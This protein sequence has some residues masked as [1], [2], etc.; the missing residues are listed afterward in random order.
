MINSLLDLFSFRTL[1]F[2]KPQVLNYLSLESAL[3]HYFT[4]ILGRL[5][6]KLCSQTLAS[7][8]KIM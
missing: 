1:I 8:Y 3:L 7:F 5:E 6:H 2:F 4:A